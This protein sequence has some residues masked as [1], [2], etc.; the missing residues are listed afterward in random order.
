MADLMKAML[1]DKAKPAALS[2]PTPISEA[3]SGNLYPPTEAE[4][5]T[6]FQRV[7]RKYR[8]KQ[9]SLAARPAA[10]GP[11]ARVG[12]LLGLPPRSLFNS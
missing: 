4:E 6:I 12:T 5:L 3:A 11:R 8:E 9:T 1:D 10:R 7:H 2:A